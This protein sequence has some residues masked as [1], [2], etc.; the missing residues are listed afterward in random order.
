LTKDVR[1]LTSDGPQDREQTVADDRTCWHGEDEGASE[2]NFAF[3]D[4]WSP[5][6]KRGNVAG[7]GE[8]IAAC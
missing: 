4:A 8:A 6:R 5:L 7:F 2:D 3:H 1:E